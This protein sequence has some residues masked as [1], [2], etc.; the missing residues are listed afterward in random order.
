MAL[1]QAEAV[2]VMLGK[3]EICA[4]M[5]HGFDRSRWVT[6]TAQQRLTL[7]PFAQ[8]HIL[9]QDDGKSRFLHHVSELSQAF[10]LAVPSDEALRIRDDVGFI[11]AVRAALAKS[12]PGSAK[13]DEDLDRWPLADIAGRRNCVRV[14]SPNF[15]SML[16]RLLPRGD[17]VVKRS[18][19]KY[20]LSHLKVFGDPGWIRTS[21]LQLRRLLLY[22]LS[23]GAVRGRSL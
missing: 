4:A 20:R 6:G 19:E 11:Q 10:A 1:D 23:Y 15:G 13:S 18:F 5:F 7:L 21:D 8:E 22:P 2:A 9:K 17:F 14:R 16:P 12:A 3:H